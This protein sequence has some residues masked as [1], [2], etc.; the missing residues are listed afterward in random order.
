MSVSLSSSFKAIALNDATKKL[1]FASVQSLNLNVQLRF[2]SVEEK[3]GL[4]AKPKKPTPPYFRFA[5]ENR[6]SIVR[7]YPDLKPYEINSILGKMWQ[8]LEAADREHFT[9]PY[10]TDLI[11]YYSND[12]TKYMSSLSDVDKRKI[13]E[14][15]VEIKYRKELA[16]QQKRLRKLDKPKKPLSSFFRYYK[17]QSDRKASEPHHDY[18]QRV[19]SRWNALSDAEKEKFKTAAEEEAAYKRAMIQW[20]QKMFKLEQDIR[21]TAKKLP[22]THRP[23]APDE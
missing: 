3:L 1:L 13:K 4:P 11:E 8:Y 7:K 15:K 16:A 12:Y 22:K 9:K 20:E 14:M 19:T 6:A 10:K 18:L 21:S 2:K 23:I 5:N 17:E